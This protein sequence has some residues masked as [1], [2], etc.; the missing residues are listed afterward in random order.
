MKLFKWLARNVFHIIGGFFIG[1]SVP[2][3]Y[4][5]LYFPNFYFYLPIGILLVGISYYYKFV[6]NN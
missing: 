2:T 6:K 1:I 5:I 3:V 4:S